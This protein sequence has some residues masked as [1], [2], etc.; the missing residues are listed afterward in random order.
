MDPKWP[1]DHFDEHN[2]KI[3]NLLILVLFLL[4][5]NIISKSIPHPTYLNIKE[6]PYRPHSF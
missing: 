2:L 4:S 1:P 6:Q 5:N 3:V